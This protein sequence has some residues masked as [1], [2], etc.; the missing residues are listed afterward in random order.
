MRRARQDDLWLMGVAAFIGLL[1]CMAVQGGCFDLATEADGRPQ[2]GAPRAGYCGP[3]DH[4]YRWLL[5]PVVGAVVAVGLARLLTGVRHARGLALAI[6]IVL[7][8][9]NVVVANTL[10]AVT[11]V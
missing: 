8:I 6:V 9:A 4:T 3:I 11:P 5:F 1:T 2:S 7:A 10:R